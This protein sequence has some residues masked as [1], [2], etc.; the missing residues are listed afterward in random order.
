M[1]IKNKGKGKAEVLIYEDVGTYFGGVTA[2]TFNEE[3]KALGDLEEINVRINSDGGD[4]YEGVAIYNSLRRNG[5][6]ITVDVDGLAASIASIIAMAGD[7]IRMASNATMMIH[8][9]W[10]VAYGFADDLRAQADLLDQVRGQLIDT[11]ARQTIIDSTKIGE[12]MDAETWMT[13]DDALEHGFIHSISDEVKI[14]AHWDL[15]RFKHPPEYLQN[16]QNV[17][18]QDTHKDQPGASAQ[19]D[20]MAARIKAIK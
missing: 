8:N 16:M 17:V 20:K 13:A 15:K 3:L 12:L 18:E 1:K 2:R 6:R 10:G 14:A 7:E 5:A 19:L 9:P 4:V 11:Y